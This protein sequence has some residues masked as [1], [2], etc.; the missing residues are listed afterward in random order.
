MACHGSTKCSPYELVYGHAAV[1]PWE[2]RT[3]S[4][5]IESQEN[6]IAGDYKVLMMDD[7]EDINCHRLCA[8]ENIEANKLRIAKYYDKKVKAKQF[9]K[10]ELVWKLILSIG[11][12]DGAYG[13]WSPNWEGPYRITRCVPGNAYFY[14]ML[15]GEEF[16]RALNGKH[17]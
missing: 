12:K 1:L 10:G 14:D 7:L 13:K 15:E 4:W 9:H 17:F 2:I 6:L 8:L 5:R 11:T 3:R 16:N